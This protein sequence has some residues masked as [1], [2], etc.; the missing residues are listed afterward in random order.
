MSAPAPHVRLSAIKF[1]YP[2]C[3]ANVLDIDTLTIETGEHVALIGATGAGKT[4]LLKLMDGRL[5]GWSCLSVGCSCRN[6]DQCHRR[7]QMCF[8]GIIE[9]LQSTEA[10]GPQRVLPYKHGVSE[11]LRH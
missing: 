4:T 6:L 3:A 7:I 2:G 9:D 5:F 1:A 11:L 8:G 10:N